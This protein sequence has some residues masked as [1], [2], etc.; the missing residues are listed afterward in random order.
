M[1]RQL[2]RKAF[3]AILLCNSINSYS[4]EN[5]PLINS[6]EVI[7]QAF[8]QQQ[9]NNYKEAVKLFDKVSKSDTNYFM[10]YFEKINTLQADSLNEEALQLA[11][12]GIKLFP[13]NY[14]K[15]AM[16]AANSLDVLH[17][18]KEAIAY[19]DTAMKINPN[20]YLIPFNMAITYFKMEAFDSAKLYFQ[21]T[22]LINP[23]HANSHYLL[24][25][26]YAL[27][28]DVIPA[29]L[30][31]ST[32]LLV[33][34]EGNLYSKAIGKISDIINGT[35]EV[36]E[37]IAKNN[38]SR[39]KAYRDIEELVFS[40]IALSNKYKSIIKLE[41]VIIKQLQA[42]NEKLEY[43]AANKSFAM[44]YYVPF[45]YNN[46]KDGYFEPLIY[47]MFASVD[48]KPISNWRKSNGKT[49]DKFTDYA[50]Q[51]FSDIR[52]T[53]EILLSKRKEVKL[54]YFYMNN[55]LVG[56]GE[57][58]NQSKNSFAV[59]PWKLFHENGMVKAAGFID[60]KGKKNGV[61]NYYYDNGELQEK[62]TFTDD[63]K[64]GISEG[65]FSNKNK[66]YRENF[67]DGKISG[68]AVTYFYNGL[69]KSEFNYM[70]GLLEGEQKYYDY[71]G[72]LTNTV[73]YK[74]DKADGK[75]IAY[76]KNKKIKSE[77]FYTNGSE[78]SDYKEYYKSGKI[79]TEGKVVNGYKDG[80]WT[81]YF[82]SGKI[83]SKTTFSKGDYTGEFVE[84]Y[85]N[86]I[87]SVRG[88]YTKKKLDGKIIYKDEDDKTYCIAEYEKGKLREIIFL[89]KAGNTVSSTST[90]KG[91]ANIVFYD[92]KG[93]KSSEGFY[94][95]E[96]N[97]QGK[98]LSYF[99]NGK[100]F[101]ESNYKDG[102]LDGPYTQYYPNGKVFLTTSYKNGTEDGYNKSVYLNGKTKT[103]GWVVNGEKQQNWITYNPMGDLYKNEYY[104]NGSPYGYTDYFYPGNIPDYSINYMNGWLVELSQFDT[105]GKNISFTKYND[106]TGDFVFYFLNGKMLSTVPQK[107]YFHEGVK[108]T[109]FF[110]G[111]LSSELNYSKDERNGKFTSY[112][113]NGNKK[114]EG[115][116]VDDQKDGEW[117]YYFSNGKEEKTENYVNGQLSGT[118]KTFSENGAPVNSI[119]Y[120]NG[121]YNGPY[122]LFAKTGDVMVVYNYKNDNLESYQ[123][124]KE[125]KELIAP[126]ILKNSSG[127]VAAKYASGKSSVDLQFDANNING[128]FKYFH[129]NGNVMTEGM[130]DNGYYN[131]EIKWYYPDGKLFKK[132]NYVLGNLHGN[133][134][135]YNED[136]SLKT[137]ENYYNDE[138]HRLSLKY[139][140]K[141]LKSTNYYHGYITEEK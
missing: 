90:K 29:T 115:N 21:K 33:Q 80:L 126:I 92:S 128:N 96:G 132:A 100:L 135:S 138:K 74:A 10:A 87:E 125:N 116:Y 136:G 129:P 67:V 61:W 32:Y 57:F 58:N 34:P 98:H 140:G 111:K 35:D 99:T 41:D 122:T 130:M 45:Y 107:N 40:K 42:I 19:Y 9:K 22:I 65:W 104:V 17:R 93:N 109:Y 70:N 81:G 18:P 78:N 86:G 26:I 11:L 59:G 4:Q 60:E 103:E 20:E 113:N 8:I 25:E 119:T 69:L 36:K 75:S 16:Q 64:N 13:E 1:P 108:K 2:I 139:D 118:V 71:K 6:G 48:I 95:K 89:D 137:D 51:Y 84:Y 79:Q 63:V 106:G 117:K 56:Q 141:V 3:I 110:N 55:K 49:L 134:K 50:S 24:G 91:A 133:Y 28:G 14:S 88:N 30:A 62:L 52:A 83:N 73:N 15:F 38:N 114:E 131:G 121:K 123:Y 124:Q 27:Q 112:Y 72:N 127:K 97:R 54:R 102:N 37:L 105:L 7:K 39:D 53:R 44:Q 23:F 5:N 68:K 82:E 120:L 43:N 31:F 94:D 66:W 77:S 12:K 76:Y 85:E 46:F 101:E 47:S